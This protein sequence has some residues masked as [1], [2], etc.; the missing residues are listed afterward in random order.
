M[1]SKSFRS[2]VTVITEHP[3][4]V[5]LVIA[6]LAVASY[7]TTQTDSIAVQAVVWFLAL[8][9]AAK[10]LLEAV[11]VS[12]SELLNRFTTRDIMVMAVLIA[13]GGVFKGY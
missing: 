7:V 10:L 3:F 11:N 4:L 9:L 8:A 2:L 1:F 5:A 12:I 6:A 13:A